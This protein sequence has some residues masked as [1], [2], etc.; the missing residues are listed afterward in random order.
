MADKNKDNKE[1]SFGKQMT[2]LLIVKDMR[3]KPKEIL[4]GVAFLAFV[5]FFLF[6]ALGRGCQEKNKL[7]EQQ[8]SRVSQSVTLAETWQG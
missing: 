7:E 8:E 6:A 1:L 4:K 3:S 2:S 5:C